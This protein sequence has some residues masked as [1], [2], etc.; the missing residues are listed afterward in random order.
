MTLER[1]IRIAAL[2]IPIFFCASPETARADNPAGDYEI[3][4]GGPNPIITIDNI[5]IEEQQCE[6]VEGVGLLCVEVSTSMPVAVDARGKISGIGSL[7]FVANG[8]D[9]EVSGTMG[10]MVSGRVNGRRD[11][12]LRDH[13]TK[14]TVRA[15]CAGNVGVT[16]LGA[17][18][19]RVT[20]R[21]KGESDDDGFYVGE[22]S[23]RVSIRGFGT[24]KVVIPVFL[25]FGNGG[26]W[27]VA[28]NIVDID[29]K[30][31]GGTALATLDDGSALSFE[32]RARYSEKRDESNVRLKPHTAF[33]GAWI[34]LRHLVVTGGAI[35][36]GE[37]KY[38][39]NGQ[40]GRVVDP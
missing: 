24:E 34:R 18:P 12:A 28:L 31:F 9:V 10:C 20:M 13:D 19:T 3:Q 26:D 35:A 33:R 5:S 11:S 2:A 1:T 15:R 29:G 7:T 4:L 23:A 22:A 21:I 39:V 27:T 40:K 25:E 14:I 17:V 37:L 38:K 32:I 8:G 30:R 16:G 6:F 36:G